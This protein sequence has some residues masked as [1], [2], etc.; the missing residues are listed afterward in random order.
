MKPQYDE[1]LVDLVFSH[2][3]LTITGHKEIPGSIDLVKD[4]IETARVY[5]KYKVRP[6]DEEVKQMLGKFLDDAMFEGANRD[7]VL[8]LGCDYHWT[9]IREQEVKAI[10]RVPLMRKCMHIIRHVGSPFSIRRFYV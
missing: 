10:Q 6:S 3:V 1:T 5:I 8:K 7:K 4:I 2:S 9:L